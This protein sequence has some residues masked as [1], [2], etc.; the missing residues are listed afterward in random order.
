MSTT[1][2]EFK[3]ES[4]I[5]LKLGAPIVATQLLQMSL[6][7][8]DTVM[9]G[10]LSALDLAGVAIGNA[11]YMPIAVFCMAT[12][13]AIN[14]IVSEHLGARRFDEIGKS[15]RQLFWLIIMLTIP[16]FFMTRN[17]DLLMSLTGVTPEIIPISSGYLKAISWG[18]LPLFSYAGIRYFSEGLSVTTPAMIIA[19]LSVIL[20]IGANYIFMYGIFGFEGMGAIGAGYATSLVNFF[21]AITFIIFTAKFKPFKR[22]NIFAKT[23]G[24]DPIVF[25]ELL[26]IGLPNGASSTMEVLLFASV[27]ILMGTLSVEASASHQIAINVASTIFMIPFGLS[28]AISQRVGFS[29]GQGS[30]KNARFRGFVGIIICGSIMILT[31]LVLFTIPDKIIAIYTDDPLVSTLSVSLLFM[32]GLFQISDGLQVGAFGALRGL[33]DTRRPMI[34]NFISYWLIGFPVGYYLGIISDFGSEGLWIG[35]VSGLSVAAILHN[36]RFNK[37]TRLT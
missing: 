18:L 2:K 22:F 36:Y 3:K 11:L 16:C 21:A 4:S 24:P 7:F 27:S 30:M 29:I 33:K 15:A 13:I 20:N 17:L 37:L 26:K 28:I 32:A 23:K 31:A 1:T 5:L 25:R 34:V 35:L 14:P 9:A 19:A 6:N 12:L 8:V 10:N